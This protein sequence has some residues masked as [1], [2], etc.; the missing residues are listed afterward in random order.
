MKTLKKVVLFICLMTC[1]GR[2]TAQTKGTEEMVV[3]LSEPGKPV[4]LEA[5]LMSGSIKV[6]GYEGK[7]VIVLVHM[8]STK[9]EDGN[10]DDDSKGM[11]K[12]G[13][14][15]GLD[16]RA[17]ENENTVRINAGMTNRKL[18]GLTIKVPQNTERIDVGTINNG[19][20]TVSNVS[21]KIE[22]SDVNGAITATGISGSVV[23]NT[24]N[25]EVIVKFKSVDPKAVMSF[26]SLNGKID[27]TLP[28]DTKAN[29]KLKSD[30][31]EMFTDFEIAVD[32]TQPKLETKNEDHFHQIKINDWISGTINGGGP[33]ITMESQFSSIYIRKAK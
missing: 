25:G 13:S 11:K 28:A 14:T 24:V 33:E 15:G 16:V 21:G 27:I 30:R 10:E 7:D 29:L 18:L 32:K 17:E 8:D 3:P 6:I 12:I 2:L 23:A 9:D 22:I 19:N 4:T 20:I 5:K 26:S 1:V 31:G